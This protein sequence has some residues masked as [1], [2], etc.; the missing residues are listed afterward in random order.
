V[1]KGNPVYE[2]LQDATSL[3][4]ERLKEKGKAVF[5]INAVSR[6]DDIHG[7][8]C[9][10]ILESIAPLFDNV[11]EIYIKEAES[12]DIVVAMAEAPMDRDLYQAMKSFENVRG[13][14][15]DRGSYILVASCPDGVGPPHFSETMELASRGDALAKHLSG[16]YRLGDHKFKNPID[17][18]DGGGTMTVVSESLYQ[19]GKEVGFFTICD[20][21]DTALKIELERFRVGDGDIRVLVVRDAVNLVIM[22]K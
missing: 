21:L 14:I 15:K 1:T 17:L 19:T 13:A 8:F 11:G 5:G 10:P 22:P 12:S 7:I 9:G 18:I 20:E 2:D 4:V 3:V 6:G 16:G